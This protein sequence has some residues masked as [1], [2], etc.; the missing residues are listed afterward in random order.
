VLHVA[1]V[2]NFTVTRAGLGAIRWLRPVDVV[3][4]KLDTIVTIQQGVS[5]LH[6]HAAHKHV[7]M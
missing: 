4:L 7:S 2:H 5:A 1:Q 3:G 6:A